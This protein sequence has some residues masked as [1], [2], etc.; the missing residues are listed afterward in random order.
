MTSHQEATWNLFLKVSVVLWKDLG[1]YCEPEIP[2]KIL[3]QMFLQI[4]ALKRVM[5]VCSMQMI[6]IFLIK[7]IVMS[8]LH[9]SGNS[10]REKL[11]FGV[12]RRRRGAP[13]NWAWILAMSCPR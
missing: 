2:S 11:P 5:F 9:K 10:H 7:K 13:L 1:G 4:P 6:Y 12:L 3:I 8:F